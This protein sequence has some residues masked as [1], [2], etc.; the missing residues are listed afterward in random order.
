MGPDWGRACNSPISSF[1]FPVYLPLKDFSPSCERFAEGIGS[2]VTA[3]ATPTLT[4]TLPDGNLDQIFL[5][6]I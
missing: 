3:L 4:L 1:D 2:I 6:E 5:E